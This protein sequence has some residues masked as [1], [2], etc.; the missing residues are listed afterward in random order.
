M[1]YRSAYMVKKNLMPE[2]P[3]Y[4]VFESLYNKNLSQSNTNHVGCINLSGPILCLRQTSC[5]M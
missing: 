2:A 1:M 3:G 4:H 5:K